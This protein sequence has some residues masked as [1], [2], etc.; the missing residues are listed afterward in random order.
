MPILIVLK[1]PRINL[2]AEGTI[3]EKHIKEWDEIFQ[4]QI[5][6]F[7]SQKGNMT[8]VPLLQHCNIAVLEEI[9]DEELAEQ[10]KKSEERRKK[11]E[12]QGGAPRP[13]SLI[14]RP[15]LGFPAGGQKRR[16]I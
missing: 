1:D 10:E 13:G 14:H 6:M 8:A 16:R 2:V 7:K 15:T 3:D 5:I 9:T 4:G 11:M 12:E